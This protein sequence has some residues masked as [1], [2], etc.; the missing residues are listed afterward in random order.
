M[1]AACLQLAALVAL[2]WRVISWRARRWPAWMGARCRGRLAGAE[3]GYAGVKLSVCAADWGG[4][5]ACGQGERQG[6]AAVHTC[7]QRGRGRPAASIEGGGQLQQRG[8]R[9]QGWATPST[10]VH[11]SAYECI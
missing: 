6:Q 4:G 7:V 2:Q 9:L 8:S 10:E 1:F 5:V 11:M 3:R